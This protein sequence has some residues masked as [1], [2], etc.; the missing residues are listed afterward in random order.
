MNVPEDFLTELAERTEQLIFLFNI[1]SNELIFTNRALKKMIESR[2]VSSF[3]PK[4]LLS[5]VHPQDQEFMKQN[6]HELLDG[7][8]FKNLEFRILMLNGS[9]CWYS[10]SAYLMHNLSDEFIVGGYAV[11]ITGLKNY[12]ATLHKFANKKNSVLN[13][14]AHD[15]AGPIG[16]IQNLTELIGRRATSYRDKEL[17]RYLKTVNR[18]SSKSVKLIKN[19]INDEFIESAEATLLKKR[20]NIV[21]AIRQIMSQYQQTQ[22]ISKHVFE[23]TSSSK[24]IYIDID[25]TKF[26]QSIN[27]LLSNAIKFTPENGQISVSIEEKKESVLIK[28]KDTGVGIPQEHHNDLFE[29][30]SGASRVGLKGEPSTGLGMSIIKTIVEWHDGQIWFESE[31]NK[32]TTFFISLPKKQSK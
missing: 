19:F 25:N 5:I 16:T 3:L 23:F 18:I 21:E 4:D 27:N 12:S 32:G 1:K 6:Y 17:E 7:K 10:V 28:I 11:E 14:L 29:K 15:L 2:N 8:E 20:T 9:V 31:I 30:F 22:N 13:I 26:I 24:A